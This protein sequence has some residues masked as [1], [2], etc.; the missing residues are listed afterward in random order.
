LL[1]PDATMPTLAPGQTMTI[2]LVGEAASP[3]GNSGTQLRLLL[4]PFL[5]DTAGPTSK[6]VDGSTIDMCELRFVHAVPGL[7]PV[8]LVTDT[9]DES[10][11]TSGGTKQLFKSVTFGVSDPDGGGYLVRPAF[12][13]DPTNF[14]V[15]RLHVQLSGADA[16]AAQDLFPPATVEAAGGSALT[17]VLAGSSESAVQLL[18]C[19]DNAGTTSL[20]SSCETLSISTCG[21][22]TVDPFEE[23]DC[24]KIGGA[25][26][27]NPQCNGTANSDSDFVAGV[28]AP[29]PVCSSTCHLR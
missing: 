6:V 9:Y 29:S 20:Y 11:G 7:G 24:G 21:N 22:G 16:G 8:D 15:P 26:S 2:A 17:L 14:S 23:C 4:P 13:A 10:T 28:A 3:P 27:T 5:D 25:V 19:I 12:N 1:V 18:G